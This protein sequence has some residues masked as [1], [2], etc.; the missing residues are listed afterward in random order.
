MFNTDQGED[1]RGGLLI[2]VEEV[3][4]R[5]SESRSKVHPRPCSH[6]W[7][8]ACRD[9]DSREA[10]QDTEELDPDSRA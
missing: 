8:R 6:S 9:K 4:E 2:A 3:L 1:H 7:N 10:R 5:I